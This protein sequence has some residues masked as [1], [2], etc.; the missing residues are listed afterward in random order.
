ML[1][2]RR[3]N[4]STFGALSEPRTSLAGMTRTC[5]CEPYLD[6]TRY[7]RVCDY[8]GTESGSVRCI[9]D[10]RQEPCPECDVLPVPQR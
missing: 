8:C 5:A 10:A 2:A 7:A 4:S 1:S 3:I 6:D 9:H